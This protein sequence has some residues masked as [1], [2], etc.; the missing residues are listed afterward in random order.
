MARL[1]GFVGNRADL[2]ARVLE[3]ESKAL[4]VVAHGATLVQHISRQHS[5]RLFK[6]LCVAQPSH[7][8]KVEGPVLSPVRRASSAH[9][10]VGRPPARMERDDPSSRLHPDRR[11]IRRS[12]LADVHASRWKRHNPLRFHC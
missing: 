4:Q 1:F 8:Q 11:S 10:S 6:R 9:L 7:N 2:G 5:R 3:L 12:N